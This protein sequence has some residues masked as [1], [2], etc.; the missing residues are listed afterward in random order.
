M[1]MPIPIPLPML[2][3]LCLC[4]CPSCDRWSW[5]ERYNGVY[6]Y[7]CSQI[8]FDTPIERSIHVPSF[9][10][11]PMRKSIRYDTTRSLVLYYTLCWLGVVCDMIRYYLVVCGSICPQPFSIC[12]SN[13]AWPPIE[14]SP[15]VLHTLAGVFEPSRADREH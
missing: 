6:M 2:V 7:T 3:C 9:Q 8:G 5:I 4:V 12:F 15:P 13:L 11:H 1:L 10:Y 14:L